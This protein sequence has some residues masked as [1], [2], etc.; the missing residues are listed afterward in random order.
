MTETLL[1]RR[2]RLLRDE[3]GQIA[4][5]LF[6]SRGF[7]VVTVDDIA[8]AT[9]T[10]QRTFFRYFASKDDVVLDLARRLE[11]RLVAALDD[12]PQTEGATAALRNAY[13]STSHVPPGERDRVRQVAT[14]L[15][16]APALSAR[17]HGLYVNENPELLSRLAQRMGLQDDDRRVRVLATSTAAVANVE[18]HRWAAAGGSGDPSEAIGAALAVLEAGL[19]VLDDCVPTD[20]DART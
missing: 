10:S 20:P 7:D 15:S 9:G 16:Q 8:E 4:V 17:A 6:A 12:R 11:K 14:V 19:A 5:G 13:C 18:F 1:D 2:R 3:I